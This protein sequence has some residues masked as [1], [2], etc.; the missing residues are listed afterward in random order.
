MVTDKEK[1]TLD[2][3]FAAMANGV[4]P[5][6]DEISDMT[7]IPAAEAHLILK[8][9]EYVHLYGGIKRCDCQNVLLSRWMQEQLLLASGKGD[10]YAVR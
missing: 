5:S 2:L 1:R 6:A 9:Y 4:L 3:Y 7:K 8:A 10:A